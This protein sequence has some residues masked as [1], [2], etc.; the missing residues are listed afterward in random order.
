MK[1]FHRRGITD[2]ES[3][4]AFYG[5]A[6]GDHSC[7]NDP[8]V[9]EAGWMVVS[10]GFKDVDITSQEAIDQIVHEIVERNKLRVEELLANGTYG[11]EYE[12]EFDIRMVE[13]PLFDGPNTT[14]IPLESYRMVLLDANNGSITEE[15]IVNAVDEAFK[16]Y[17][18]PKFK[19]EEEWKA[20]DEA[21]KKAAEDFTLD[22]P[23]D[24][25]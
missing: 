9:F 22:T 13:N 23:D 6:Q 12:T 20:F 16:G 2:L 25:I 7:S 11:E 4:Y 3:P 15:M 18:A 14:G 21:M 19:T 10:H 24:K 8:K 5:A 17:K 1:N